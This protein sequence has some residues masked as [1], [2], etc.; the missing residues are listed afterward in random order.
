MRRGVRGPAL[1]RLVSL[2]LLIGLLAGCSKPT[3][4]TIVGGSE[5]QTLEPIVT[6]F[7]KQQNVDCR[8][9]YM[10][11]VD[12]SLALEQADFPYDAVWA[13][14]SL[15]IDIGDQQRRVK[16]LKSIMRSP[17][18]LGVRKSLAEQLGFVDRKVETK[19]IL[20]AVESGK[21]KFLMTSATQSNSGASAYLGFLYAALGQPEVLTEADLQRPDV[22]DK[23]RRLLAGVQRSAGSSGWLKDLFLTGA[24]DGAGYDAMVNYEALIIEANQELA[25]LGKEPLYVVYPADG[26][27]VADSPLGFV[28]H[29][30]ADSEAF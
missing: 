1:P 25:K 13:A 23:V 10:G 21:L 15:W 24:K 5:N 8:F 11:A 26:V 3:P 20:A 18:V 6:E 28:P 22:K 17:V 14:N 16:D 29:G 30:N 2:M 9:T 19:D 7:C 4:F 12:I 27:A